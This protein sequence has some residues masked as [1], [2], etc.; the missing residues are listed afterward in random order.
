MANYQCAFTTSAT[1]EDILQN[2]TIKPRIMESLGA[3]TDAQYA[4]FFSGNNALGVT[5]KFDIIFS[6]DNKVSINNGIYND[7]LENM[8]YSSGNYTKLTS[9]KVQSVG[10]GVFVFNIR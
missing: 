1:N 10:S 5:M 3:T 9:L 2:A 6:A 8:V 4:T 7:L